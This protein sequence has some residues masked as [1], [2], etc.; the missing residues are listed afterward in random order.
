MSSVR[1]F[2]LTLAGITVSACNLEKGGPP[3]TD[4]SR[5]VLRYLPEVVAIYPHV[6]AEFTEGFVYR[7]GSIYES[8][9]PKG[10]G[11]LIEYRLG[12]EET[13]H[14]TDIETADVFP[15]GLTFVGDLLVQLTEENQR[16]YFY[17]SST[18]TGIRTLSFK[19]IG[20]GLTSNGSELIRSDGSSRLYF[21]NPE[22]L[23]LKRSISVREL[24]QAVEKINELE[25]ISGRIYANVWFK[26]EILII[27]PDTG[28][29]EGTIDTSTVSDQEMRVRPHSV[30]NGIAYRPE[31]G[32]ILLTGKRWD[33][34]YEVDL[35]LSSGCDQKLLQQV[36]MNREKLSD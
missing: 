16:A 21:H 7:D 30:I 36:E 34:I 22:T 5:G 3:A 2:A 29:V 10:V 13:L 9:G 12:S 14:R 15:E 20:W 19:G 35:V 4:C 17:D 6:G 11:G 25:W 18:L 1:V 8:F 31:T 24:G 28:R 26:N 27:N 33:R 32:R 23:E